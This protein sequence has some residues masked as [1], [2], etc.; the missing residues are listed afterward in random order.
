MKKILREQARKFAF[1]H[2]DKPL[3]RVVAGE[4]IAFLD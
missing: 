2:S 3:I 4:R 1:D